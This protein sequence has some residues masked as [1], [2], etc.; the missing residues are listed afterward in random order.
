METEFA[1]SRKQFL[2][3]VPLCTPEQVGVLFLLTQKHN[4]E[5]LTYDDL[6]N[7]QIDMDNVTDQM[8]SRL[9][10]QLD[11]WGIGFVSSKKK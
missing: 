11:M 1:R 4:S 7:V 5:A 3:F 9:V 10:D 8:L 2:M 6:G